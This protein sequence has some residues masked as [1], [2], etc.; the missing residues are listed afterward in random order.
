MKKFVS[1][2]LACVMALSLCA[3]ALA[4]NT[5]VTDLAEGAE[6]ELT[7]V[8]KGATIQVL[9]PTIAT[10]ALNPYKMNVK[11][12]NDKLV[13]DTAAGEQI[14]SPMYQIEN[15]STLGV[16]VAVSVTGML[17]GTGMSFV[18]AKHSTSTTDTTKSAFVQMQYGLAAPGSTTMGTKKTITLKDR[19]AV[20]NDPMTMLRYN[21][22][23]TTNTSNLLFNFIGS[24][25]EKSAVAWSDE[26]TISAT[27]AFTF[28]VNPS[29]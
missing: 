9:V 27:I 2:I 11:L 6:L 10:I 29:K 17:N 16:D 19:E 3:T 5:T 13:D 14:I 7:S 4:A 1:L 18:E 20:T 12:E 24:L 15:R 25:N 22:S 28:T 26:D 23:S 8:T 21:A